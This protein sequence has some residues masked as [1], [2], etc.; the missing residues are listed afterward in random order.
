MK[1]E[2]LLNALA[3]LRGVRK[4]SHSEITGSIVVYFDPKQQHLG[5]IL[6]IFHR[7]KLLHNVLGLP[8]APLRRIPSVPSKSGR[9][10]WMSEEME[11]LGRMILFYLLESALQKS[12]RVLI[13]KVLG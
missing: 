12:S 11:Q 13:R 4:I 3:T 1:A 7:Y 2:A 5:T 8:R 6:K 9:K 10:P